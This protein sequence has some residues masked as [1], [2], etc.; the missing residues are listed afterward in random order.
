MK[1]RI[2]FAF[3]L[4]LIFCNGCTYFSDRGNDFADIFTL[5]VENGNYG[6]H[7]QVL[8]PLGFSYSDGG[9][10]GMRSGDMGK[11]DYSD[12]I[13]HV[14]PGIPG[15]AE[16]SFTPVVDERNKAY[17]VERPIPLNMRVF[18]NLEVNVG[19]H[20]GLRAGFNLAELADFIIGLTT[21][22]I[23]DDD[24]PAKCTK[25]KCES[26]ASEKAE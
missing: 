23:L 16:R 7:A 6:A 25:K 2:A 10:A 11:Y 9:G 3:V 8:V 17:T 12:R 20:Y 15:V 14:F 26:E 24:K 19:A 18:W 5:S 13:I 22:D 21:F 1:I 4:C